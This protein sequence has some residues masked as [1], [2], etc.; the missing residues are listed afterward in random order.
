MSTLEKKLEELK[1]KRENLNNT[2]GGLGINLKERQNKKTARSIRRKAK[3]LRKSFTKDMLKEFVSKTPDMELIHHC[4]KL[5]CSM[6]TLS[7]ISRIFNE[8]SAGH[9]K[10]RNCKKFDMYIDKLIEEIKYEK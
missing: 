3:L 8:E 4:D 5:Q 6:F 9:K 1:Q 2:L 7:C 10:C